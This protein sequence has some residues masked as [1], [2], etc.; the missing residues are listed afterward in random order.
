MTEFQSTWNGHLGRIIR[1]EMHPIDLEYESNRLGDS[2]VYITGPKAYESGNAEIHEMFNVGVI[3]LAKLELAT[4]EILDSKREESIAL[5]CRLLE[6][7]IGF[8]LRLQPYTGN[9]RMHK[10][11]RRHTNIL[12][13]LNA[14]RGYWQVVTKQPLL[15]TMGS[16]GFQKSSFECA[17][18]Q[19]CF[20]DPWMY[21]NHLSTV[22]L[23]LLCLEDIII[24]SQNA[25]EDRS[26]DQTVLSILPKDG[27]TFKLKKWKYF[28]EKLYYLR[29]IIR[30]AKLE[31]AG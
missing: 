12:Y 22:A 2:A 1:V 6:A 8:S 17:M 20:N 28:Y 10:I 15:R 18:H 25:E 21:Y 27:F 5:L 24:F 14:S 16:T 3:E 30:P 29:N 13:N 7:I 4:H 26:H 9:G 19:T 31:L 11:I 23:A